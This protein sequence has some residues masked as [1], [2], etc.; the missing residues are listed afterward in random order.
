MPSKTKP[1]TTVTQ[2][3]SV[4]PRGINQ[5]VPPT[6]SSAI[7]AQPLTIEAITSNQRNDNALAIN[8]HETRRQ[9]ALVLS[10]RYEADKAEHEADKAQINAHIAAIEVDIASIKAAVKTV[11]RETTAVK[12]THQVTVMQ[13]S[14]QLSANKANTT[15]AAVT[16]AVNTAKAQGVATTGTDYQ[17]SIQLPSFRST[18]NTDPSRGTGR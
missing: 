9:N 7:T 3:L 18:E 14:V 4:V 2:G 1:T 16:R 13:S 8:L 17:V 11:E 6:I 5:L 10:A 15:K 12:A